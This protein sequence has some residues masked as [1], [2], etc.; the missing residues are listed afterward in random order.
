LEQ[1]NIQTNVYY[2]MPLSRQ[3][4]YLANY[5]S[6]PELPMAQEV[7]E[8]I[9]A[10]PFYPEISEDIIH[11]VAGLVNEFYVGRA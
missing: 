9:I 5:P 8:R 2:P 3:K 7:S 6:P 1:R 11:L 10:L 4:A